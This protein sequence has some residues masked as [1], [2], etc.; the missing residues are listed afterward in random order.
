[1]HA[2]ID[3]GAALADW[4]AA[5]PAA[6]TI[7]LDT[8]F[9]RT[10]TFSARLALMQ[11]CSEDD[12]A[13]IDTV[14]LPRPQALIERLAGPAG[15]CIMHS[16]GEDLEAMLPLLPDGPAGLFDTQIAAAMAG[17]GFGLS[18]QKLVAQVLG[19]ELAKA[20]TRSD[21]LQ[22]P[23]S[24]AQLDYAAQDVVWLPAL[25]ETLRR[26]LD[27]LGR[28]AWLLEDC[29]SLVDRVCHA[30]PDPQ[31]HRAFRGAADWPIERQAMLRR[32]LLWRDASARALD[33]PKPWIL[34]DAHALGLASKPPA[35]ADELYERTRGLRALR[36]PQRQALFALL[37]APLEAGDLAIVPAPPPLDP[38]QKRALAAMKDAVA[39][40]AQAIGLPEALLCP[41]RHLETLLTDHAWPAALEGWRK[42]LLQE[43]LL[44]L[45]PHKTPEPVAGSR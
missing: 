36:G 9:M 11:L 44:G 40:I 25:H 45:M 29:R 32:L 39:S 19:V 18:Y 21:W 2:W 4:L 27:E 33:K 43:A 31:P 1:M 13:L 35:S 14:A 3:T 7:G 20:E 5:H 22:R 23:L 34:D 28:S 15:V 38:T 10:N 24:A 17:L 12:I 30:V 16:A 8:E 37:Q 6:T 41:R 26:K 42:G